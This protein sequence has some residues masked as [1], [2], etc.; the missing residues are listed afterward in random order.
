VNIAPGSTTGTY[1]YTD[2]AILNTNVGVKV[3]VTGKASGDAEVTLMPD[4]SVSMHLKDTAHTFSTT[5]NK[6][7]HGN[8]TPTTLQTNVIIWNPGADC[9]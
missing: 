7:G 6:G 4:G 5:T 2:D 1:T 9:P 3:Y 8:D